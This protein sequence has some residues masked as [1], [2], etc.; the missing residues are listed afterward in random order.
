[1]LLFE[2][3]TYGLKAFNSTLEISAKIHMQEKQQ[4]TLW[5]LSHPKRSWTSVLLNFIL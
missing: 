5:N 3:E 1:M 4:K 2:A